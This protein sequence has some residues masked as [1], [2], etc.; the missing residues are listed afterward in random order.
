MCTHGNCPMDSDKIST[1]IKRVVFAARKQINLKIVN[2]QLHGTENSKKTV[3]V[4][5]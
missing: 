5:Y 4:K 3:R 1:V 2:R